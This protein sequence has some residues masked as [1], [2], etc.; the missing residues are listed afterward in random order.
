MAKI[1]L[2]FLFLSVAFGFSIH[3]FRQMNNLKRWDLIKTMS[4]AIMCSLGAIVL[5]MSIVVLF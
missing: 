3:T 5:M 1:I 4:F 2:C